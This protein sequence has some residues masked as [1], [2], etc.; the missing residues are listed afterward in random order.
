MNGER[1]RPQSCLSAGCSI[2]AREELRER[3]IQR[4]I[5]AD[6]EVLHSQ[7]AATPLHLSK[8]AFELAPVSLPQV[9]RIGHFG[10]LSLQPSKQ[11][12]ILEREILLGR[13][14]HLQHADVVAAISEVL[15]PREQRGYVVEQVAEDDDQSASANALREI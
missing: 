5:G 2:P 13:I 4:L 7:V 8:K 12:G 3:D 6:R 15:Q 11:H 1:L 14:D 10:R 9:A